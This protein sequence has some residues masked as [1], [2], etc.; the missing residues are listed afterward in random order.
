MQT[1]RR[2]KTVSQNLDPSWNQTFEFA[3][4]S[5]EEYL[6]LKC[7]DA[8]MLIDDSLGSARVNVEGLEDDEC[9]DMWVPLANMEVGEIRLIIKMLP[10]QSMSNEPEVV[11]YSYSMKLISYCKE[12]TLV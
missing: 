2:T 1:V 8:D 11:C 5:G 10:S 7:Y 6:R 9:R 4:I 3:E 12:N